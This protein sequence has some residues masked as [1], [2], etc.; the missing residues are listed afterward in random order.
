MITNFESVFETAFSKLK[1]VLMILKE[2]F[3]TPFIVMKTK[4]ISSTAVG[5]RYFRLKLKKSYN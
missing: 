4:L 2:L 3:K 1:E 5:K